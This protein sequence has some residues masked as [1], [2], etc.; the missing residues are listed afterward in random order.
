MVG[1]VPFALDP[2][3]LP[4]TGAPKSAW[5]DAARRWAA[6]F[7]ECTGEEWLSRHEG[8]LRAAQYG[9]KI[10]D[11]T[12][13]LA[14]RL[15]TA[16]AAMSGE[17]VA[18]A[19]GRKRR[20]AGSATATYDT[21]T[22]HIARRTVGKRPRLFFEPP[23]S[24]SPTYLED[25]ALP[26][27]GRR[28]RTDRRVLWDLHTLDVMAHAGIAGAADFVRW[29]RKA[30]GLYF[31]GALADEQTTTKYHQRVGRR[32]SGEIKSL[33]PF[34][35]PEIQMLRQYFARRERG[36]HG[37]RVVEDLVALLPGRS[38]RGI[39]R[40]LRPLLVSQAREMGWAEFKMSGWWPGG[41]LAQSIFA[42]VN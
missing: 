19:S 16:E 23:F 5:F 33:G 2:A 41:K 15:D 17:V 38:A 9:W 18:K 4:E 25:N 26:T 24:V 8:Q 14:L 13:V 7:F 36:S 1:R 3:E 28:L 10:P 42:S 20:V 11:D 21:F 6:A 27:T 39:Q 32:L 40:A 12:P 31:T 22:V 29:V 35:K 37:P 30:E 34:S